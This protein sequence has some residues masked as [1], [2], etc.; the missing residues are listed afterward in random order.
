[1]RDYTEWQRCIEALCEEVER[2]AA[3]L[4]DEEEWSEQDALQGALDNAVDDRAHHQP[5]L[6]EM[7]TSRQEVYWAV[8]AK[9]GFRGTAFEAKA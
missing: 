4:R 7:D 1:M 9:L 6:A 5:A 3:L 2:Q 8:V